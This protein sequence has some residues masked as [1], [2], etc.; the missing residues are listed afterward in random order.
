MAYPRATNYNS[1]HFEDDSN[2]D[3]QI[4]K[5][6]GGDRTT[7]PLYWLVLVLLS[8]AAE[9]APTACSLIPR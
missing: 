4:L 6:V 7:N 9:P 1:L 5:V 2:L 3:V 8:P